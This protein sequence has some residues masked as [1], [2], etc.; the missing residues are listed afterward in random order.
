MR[1]PKRTTLALLAALVAFNIVVRYPRTPHDLGLDGFVF[2]GMARTIVDF[3]HARWIL[4]PLSYLGLYP[5]SH[6][7][8]SMFAVAGFALASGLP[9]E[10]SIYLV[11][12]VIIAV[13][14]LSAF[15]LSMEIR[16]DE[17]LA[18]LVAALFSLAP[19]FVVSLLWEMPT[20]SLFAALVPLFVA[21]LIR[22]HAARSPR[23]L[24]LSVV[25]LVV[26]MSAHRLTVLM[27]VVLVGFVLTSIAVVL[28]KT[29]RIRYSAQLLS[30]KYRRVLNTLAITAFFASSVALLILGG[31]LSSYETG[32][33]A[34]GS[35][36]LIQVTNLVVSLTRSIGFLMPLLPLGIIVI[37]RQRSKEF[38]E[39]FLLMVF[40][41]LIPTLTLR[42][43]VGYYVISFSA[44]FLGL[45]V[46]WLVQRARRRSIRLS[47]A[48]AAV[49][50]TVASAVYVVDF[51]LQF[52]AFLDD[53]SYTNGLYVRHFTQGTVVAN[54]G[55]LGSKIFMVSG[56]PYLP[57]GGATTAFQS[58]ELLI[59]GFVDRNALD[60]AS[61]P[62]LDMTLESDSP[63]ILRDVQ[64]EADWAIM[65]NGRLDELLGTTASTYRPMYLLENRD[66]PSAY[67][68]Y[69]FR[70]D[71]PFIRDVHSERYKIFEIQNQALWYLGDSA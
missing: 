24:L 57:V 8:G 45:A 58:P 39:P 20:R 63:F 52:G 50:I 71:S 15:F 47:I 29:L 68:A 67:F 27:T 40:L 54:D 21:L 43:Y 59:F 44:M 60:I 46:W 18:I 26:M 4:H 19:R 49:A 33:V 64:A 9:V 7:S 69:G 12:L 36:V 48:A 32:R 23:W 51:D 28:A 38:K 13:G 1:L 41:I 35:G 6:P 14:A 5:L 34:F 70:Y 56:R 66:F 3:G 22:W 31:V 53:T 17:V 65:L 25:V 62:L 16:R 61:T 42:Q 11:D 55:I 37:Y 2:H 10:G 30:R